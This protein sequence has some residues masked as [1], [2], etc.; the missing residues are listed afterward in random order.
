MCMIVD[1]NECNEKPDVCPKNSKCTD[2]VGK[3]RCTCNT[4]Y[5]KDGKICKGK[6]D[7][8]G[9]LRHNDQRSFH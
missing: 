9:V 5:E 7:F 8:G 4:G 2:T 6:F 3:Y 1:I